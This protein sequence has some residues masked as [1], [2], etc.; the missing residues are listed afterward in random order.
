MTSFGANCERTVNS[1]VKRI[2]TKRFRETS[3]EGAG[4]FIPTNPLD[5][6]S[7]ICHA[8]LGD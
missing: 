2:G 5:V 8:S 1:F 4:N 3:N 6:A 7:S